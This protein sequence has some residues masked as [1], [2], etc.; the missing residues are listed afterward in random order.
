MYKYILF[1]I[2]SAKLRFTQ[3][4]TIVIL[5]VEFSKPPY[6]ETTEMWHGFIVTS[7]SIHQAL[8]AFI[9]GYDKCKIKM[10]PVFGIYIFLIF[11]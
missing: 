3:K 4:P 2:N 5:D 7:L 11:L 1:S 6:V 8:K 10:R 9:T